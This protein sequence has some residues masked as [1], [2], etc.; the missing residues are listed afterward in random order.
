MDFDAAYEQKINIAAGF[1]DDR[2]PEFHSAFGPGSTLNRDTMEYEPDP[3]A[4]HIAILQETLECHQKVAKK[5]VDFIDDLLKCTWEDVHNEL[6]KAKQAQVLSERRGSRNP[7]R[8]FWRTLGT[9]GS[10]LSPGLSAI[11]D[12][13]CVLHGGLAVVFSLARHSEMNRYKILS[14]FEKLPNIIEEAENKSNAFPLDNTKPKTVILDR[15]VRG[16]RMLLVQSLPALINILIPNSFFNNI[17][18][19][20]RGCK[21]D[22]VLDEVAVCAEAVRVAAE[23]LIVDIHV[24]NHSVTKDIQS[25]LDEMIKHTRVLQMSIEANQSKT[26]L[27]N[28]LMD[29]GCGSGVVSIDGH[30]DR[31]QFGKISPLSYV[32]AMLAQAAKNAQQL[33]APMLPLAEKRPQS[34]S[35]VL[36]FY[37]ALHAGTVENADD[38]AGPQGL[39]RC[40]SA[41]LMLALVANEVVGNYNPVPLPHLRDGE[42]DRL[43]DR[44]LSAVCRLFVE[45]ARLVPADTPIYCLID[46]WSS[47]EREELWQAD[48]DIVLSTFDD[49]AASVNSSFKLLL[50]SPTSSRRLKDFVPPEQRVSLRNREWSGREW[51]GRGGMGGLARAATIAE[52]NSGFGGGYYFGEDDEE[53]R[54]SEPGHSRRTSQ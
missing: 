47:Y 28:F 20:F 2:A 23:A 17:R 22:R 54:D 1:I 53:R 48:Y 8:G 24:E 51:S 12:E 6:H 33:G 11:P 27:L 3:D 34:N 45:L 43:A 16:L 4:Q 52:I 46:S 25:K 26:Q 38:L 36:E 44:D 14:A 35:I 7:I 37:C 18:S 15:A 10:I 30:F 29:G 5:Y 42:E 21:I 39:M 9:S 32:C 50:T 19:P 13:L 41:Q 40:L 31:S 49:V